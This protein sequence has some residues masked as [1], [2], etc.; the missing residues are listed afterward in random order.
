MKT[1]IKIAP[2]LLAFLVCSFSQAE[3]KTDPITKRKVELLPGAEHGIYKLLYVNEG[4][5]RVNVQIY[6]S[7]GNRV[8]KTSMTARPSFMLPIDLTAR[9]PGRYQVKVIDRYGTVKKNVFLSNELNT[10]VFPC[11]DSNKY[12][13]VV[14]NGNRE[15]ILKVEIFD[16]D[17]NL[18]FK[19][20]VSFNGGFTKMYDL[21]DLGSETLKFHLCN[22][23]NICDWFYF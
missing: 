2:L 5:H 19:E 15:Q 7:K 18:K 21:A 9:Q 13:V 22:G 1:L 12:R 20:S 6:D 8:W 16:L 3:E 23:Q 14:K 4:T 11:Q 10:S 17:G